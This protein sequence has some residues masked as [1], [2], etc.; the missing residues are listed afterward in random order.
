MSQIITFYSYKGGVGRSMAL[1]NVATLLSKWGKKVLMIDWDLEAPGLENFFKDALK[2]TDWS[3]QKGVL[4]LLYAQQNKKKAKWQ[5]WV[6]SF[7]TEIS[8]EPLHLLISGKRNGDYAEMLRAFNVSKFYEEHDGGKF[9]ESFREELLANYDYVLIDSRTGVTDFGG[10]CTIQMP[11]ILVMLFTPTEQGLLGTKRTAERILAGHQNLPFDRFRLLI[12]PVPSR[13][14]STTEFRESRDWLNRSALELETLYEEWLPTDVKLNDF[15][16]II[17]IPYISYFSFG[18][19]LPVVE[20][21]MSDPAGLG[22]AYENLAML[23]ARK[24]EEMNIFIEQRETY[25]QEIGSQE[26]KDSNKLPLSVG[27]SLRQ[28][29]IFISFAKADIDVK[30]KLVKQI[31]NSF[32][33][34]YFEFIYTKD[35]GVGESLVNI[36]QEQISKADIVIILFTKDYVNINNISLYFFDP[37]IEPEMKKEFEF[38]NK[39]DKKKVIPVYL[40]IKPVPRKYLQLLISDRVGIDAEGDNTNE[41]VNNILFGLMPTITQIINEK[42]KSHI[43]I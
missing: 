26:A 9:I 22:Y 11:D 35:V 41:I 13:F 33:K 18:E 37:R 30:D 38:I 20:Q 36:L 17:K 12:C 15:L 14:D 8:K 42:N 31:Q 21:G 23:L 1:A 4:D 43:V 32:P 34:N 7:K 5:D 6:L 24:L 19:K 10:I 29:K 27:D 3:K 40:N 16:Q 2:K 25:L 28:V 39:S